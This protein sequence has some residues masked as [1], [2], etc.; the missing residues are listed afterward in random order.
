MT[1]A[2]IRRLDAPAP[3]T[4][5]A[6]EQTLRKAAQEFEG[7][8]VNLLLKSM[9]STVMESDLIDNKGEM[10]T[11]RDM[12]DQKMAENLGG[13]ENGLGVADMI[14][15]RYMPMLEA[16]D[17]SPVETQATSLPPMPRPAVRRALDAYGPQALPASTPAET[18]MSRARDAGTVVADTLQTY[19]PLIESA[20]ERT[21][22]D[23]ELILAVIVKESSGR[24]DAQS[25]AGAQGLMQLMP[26]TA[27]EMGVEDPL[28]PEQNIRGGADYLAW[29]SKRFDGDLPLMLAGY[30]AGPGNVERAGRTVPPFEETRNYVNRVGDLYT[31]LVGA[32]GTL[33]AE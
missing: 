11:Y 26:K 17:T 22:L 16:L 8:F 12:L 5:A 7:M 29:L 28:D 18:L 6:Q 1:S 25:R 21:G 9:R 19:G 33:E 15:E 14:I 20:A 24:P 32:D 30:N 13:S 27:A 2:P 10:G 3:P 31:R 23:P 4:R